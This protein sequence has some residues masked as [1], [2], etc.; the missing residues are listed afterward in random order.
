ME[1]GAGKVA[2]VTGGAGGIGYALATAF[3][4]AGMSVVVA[5]VQDDALEQAASAISD[6]G[7]EVLAIRTDVSKL[8]QVEALA[9]ATMER[10]GAVHVVC[11]NAGVAAKG[12]PWLGP[13]SSWEWTMGVNFWGVVYGVR[14]FLPHIVMSGGG[15]IVN[16][17]S[18]AGLY[19]GFGPSYDASKHAVVA[20]TEGLFTSLATAELPVGVSCLC[21]GWVK[22]G[23]IDSERN[24]PDELGERPELDAARAV[25]EKHVRRAVDEGMPPKVVADLV[26]AAIRDNRYWIFPHPDF[27]DIAMERFHR[28][29]DGL[30][31]SPPEEFPGMPPRSQIIAEV[32]AAMQQPPG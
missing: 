9:A 19:P 6:L 14:A 31:P 21:P 27:V 22:T 17:A 10:F 3:A 8:D 29:G 26:L 25:S 5:D 30:D 23:I 13:I 12:D 15:H 20:M 28:I 4:E 32:M 1:L 24:W 18:I 11:N 16:T 2:V 7:V